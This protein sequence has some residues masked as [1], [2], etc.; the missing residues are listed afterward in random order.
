MGEDGFDMRYSA[1]GMWGR[2]T[3]FASE[4]AYCHQ[5]FVF[6]DP[7]TQQF[8]LFLAHVLAGDSVSLRP[9]ASIKMPPLKHASN[10]RFDSVNGVT[11]GCTVYIIYK[12]D[13]AYPAYLIT[14]T[15]SH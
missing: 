2:G 4:A 9:D 5:G 6:R 12:L 8:Q 1:N 15:L 13:M 11:N 7:Q 14:Y 10:I 3:Y